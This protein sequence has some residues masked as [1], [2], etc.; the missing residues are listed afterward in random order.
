MSS[1]ETGFNGILCGVF[2]FN[3]AVCCNETLNNEHC[4][5][6]SSLLLLLVFFFFFTNDTSIVI[7]FAVDDSRLFSGM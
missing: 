7:S 2:L 1:S 3:A 5:V 6:E 4:F